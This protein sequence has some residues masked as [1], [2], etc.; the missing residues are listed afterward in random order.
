MEQDLE[1]M[2][3]NTLAWFL[4][5]SF[6]SFTIKNCRVVVGYVTCLFCIHAVKYVLTTVFYMGVRTRGGRGGVEDGRAKP[7]HFFWRVNTRAF[8]QQSLNCVY[9]IIIIMIYRKYRNIDV[10]RSILRGINLRLTS[11]QKIYM[12]S[13]YTSFCSWV[14]EY[15]WLNLGW[16]LQVLFLAQC[17]ALTIVGLGFVW[18]WWGCVRVNLT[19]HLQWQCLS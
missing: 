11:L 17:P 3:I 18:P 7:P 6:W 5:Y 14:I 10:H 13:L 9:N 12:Y 1:Y 8:Y 2:F 4:S 16:P 15:W 19:D